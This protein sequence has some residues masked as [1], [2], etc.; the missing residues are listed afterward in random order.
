MDCTPTLFKV[1]IDGNIRAEERSTMNSLFNWS[2]TFLI[3]IDTVDAQHIRLHELINNLAS[4]A[5]DANK[6]DAAWLEKISSSLSPSS[7][8]QPST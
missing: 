2:E 5:F 1:S 7:R 4:S 8:S 3:G 6:E